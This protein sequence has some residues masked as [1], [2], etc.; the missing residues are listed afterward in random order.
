MVAN[1]LS[2]TGNLKMICHFQATK[3]ETGNHK[4]NSKCKNTGR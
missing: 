4:Y 2:L 1:S 3:E